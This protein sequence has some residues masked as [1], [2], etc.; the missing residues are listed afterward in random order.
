MAPVKWL[1]VLFSA[2]MLIGFLIEHTEAQ[3]QS[4]YDLAIVGGYLI[5]G[6]EG[7]PVEH[8][9]VLVR[10][11]RIV[12]V[13]TLSNTEIPDGVE[14]VDA[15]GYTVLPG[16]HDTHVHLF[17]IGHGIYDQWFTRY[18]YDT[19]RT[20][21]VM[22][23]SAEQLLRAGVTTA[24]DVGA[25]LEESI[26]IREEIESGNIAGP[27]LLVSGP[28]LQ[29]R[30]GETS[31]QR[32][33]RWAVDGPE[34]ARRKTRDLIDA[35]VDLI[36]VIQVAELTSDER[37]AIR[38]EARAAGLHIAIHAEGEE[39]IR[40]GIELGATS[41]EHVGGG[42]GPFYDET[43]AGLIADHGI[44]WVPT[45]MVSR[46]YE[47]TEASPQR[48]DSQVLRADL[49]PDLYEDVRGS[50]NYFSRLRYF[51]GK[52]EVSPHY[53]TKVS[54]LHNMGVRIAVGTDSGTPMNFHYEAT[55][56]EMELLVEYG[57][58]PMRVISAAT[59]IPAEMYGRGNEVGTIEEGKLADIIVVRGN[60]LVRMS[61][62]GD[63]VRVIKGG[64]QFD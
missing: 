28:F 43:S 24:R 16:L 5:D 29:K 63:V 22:K 31:S 50:L 54:Q 14:V 45:T 10:G 38:D 26:W 25:P 11:D 7:E 20:R 55:W 15:R 1:V 47:I 34:D 39:E 17:I 30:V 37:R 51:S 13:G 27:R 8:S 41:I 46:V 3:T 33:F 36:K 58:P 4:Q 61:A 59:R 44:Y 60:P 52:R 12:H 48:L 32:F 23:I 9:V 57:M 53:E 18:R 64:K 19:D 56:Q 35:G 2:T 40:A 6:N 49:P 62:L 42:R 21:E